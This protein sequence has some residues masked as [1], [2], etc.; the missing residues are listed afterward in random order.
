[1]N[2]SYDFDNN[3]VIYQPN[4]Y[5]TN[6]SSGY[7]QT[8]KSVLEKHPNFFEYFDI[9][10]GTYNL[11]NIRPKVYHSAKHKQF[12]DNKTYDS[13]LSYPFSDSTTYKIYDSI[14]KHN[15]I[16]ERDDVLIMSKKFYCYEAVLYYNKYVIYS[17]SSE[18]LDF[19]LFRE[20]G[21]K[22]HY[23]D[24]KVRYA[25]EN[26]IK[27][28]IMSMIPKN[29][30]EFTAEK[31]YDVVMIDTNI[32]ISGLKFYG[33]SYYIFPIVLNSI[34]MALSAIKTGGNIFIYYPDISTKCILNFFVYLGEYFESFDI[35]YLTLSDTLE[36]N[37]HGLVYKNYSGNI[38]INDLVNFSKKICI[39]NNG[40]NYN[41][42]FPNKNE[43]KLLGNN[44]I[45]SNPPNKFFSNFATNNKKINI[46]YDNNRHYILSLFRQKMELLNKIVDISVK[47]YT[48]TYISN[49]LMENRLKA[50]RYAKSLNLDVAEWVNEGIM[51]NY[52]YDMS[53]RNIIHNISP[54]N[55]RFL[56]CT[57]N[58]NIILSDNIRY[59]N[60]DYAR[61]LFIL[62]ENVYKYIDKISYKSYKQVELTFNN[63]Q[64]RLQKLLFNK[65]NININGRYVSRAWIKI[66]ELY[67]ELDYFSNLL[68]KNNNRKITAFHI[69][70]APGN[71]V[72]SSVYY[73]NLKKIDYEW[74][75]QSLKMSD[76]WDEYGFIKKTIDKWDFGKTSTGDIMD[77]DNLKYY[78]NKYKG[79]DSLVGDCGV[80]W[81]PEYKNTKDLSVYQLLYALLLPRIG[82]NFVVK[83][84][85]TNYNTQFLSLLYVCCYKY[86]SMY[87]YRS[88]RNIWSPEIYIV[89]KGKKELTDKEIKILF[90]IALSAEKNKI[91]YPVE[92][93]PTEFGYEF[94]YH[95]RNIINRFSD[96]KKFWTYL[97]RYP[98]KFNLAKEDINNA[99]N[100]KNKLWLNNY[101][102]YLEN[103]NYNYD[104]F[105]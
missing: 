37:W 80:P 74:N 72:N 64:K 18:K 40:D 52:Y 46:L 35:N 57:D 83:T 12:I 102:P 98:D 15:I 71:F 33:R 76:I 78:Y 10:L 43:R 3:I 47:G 31:K 4:L 92:Y 34:I 69:C 87:I 55:S 60:K 75:G 65:Y 14:N 38:N 45:S 73:L 77:Y 88:S 59:S 1:M 104:K 61:N 49:I 89:G 41:F 9:L 13:V 105:I 29:M 95:S 96:I 100:K 32:Y 8:Y 85:A 99:I 67:N 84:Y 39:N 58:V 11:S 50:I 56:K 97:A 68:E 90:D 101:M 28:S 25:R 20:K 26:K 24:K 44:Y 86:N 62:S 81:D 48:A 5:P 63:M 54:Y 93:I 19:I 36:D 17:H 30:L 53:I 7:Y 16:K 21:T 103:V 66:Y 91:K 2:T 79:V 6:Y 27:Y 22:D 70:E 42:H 94:E 51:I 23:F 82:G